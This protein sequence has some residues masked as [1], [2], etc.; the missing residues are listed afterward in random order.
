MNKLHQHL[1]CL[2]DDIAICVIH[3][4]LVCVV[5]ALVFIDGLLNREEE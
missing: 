1:L 5:A 4:V 3:S 2:Y